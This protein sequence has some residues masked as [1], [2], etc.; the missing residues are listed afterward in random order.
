MIK[1][2]IVPSI[3]ALIAAYVVAA[4]AL[5]LGIGHLTQGSIVAAAILT[6]FATLFVLMALSCERKGRRAA[7]ARQS[8]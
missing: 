1:E 7:K 6:I 8:R 4:A 2:R 3:I 5:V